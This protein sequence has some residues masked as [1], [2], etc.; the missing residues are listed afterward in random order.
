MNAALRS[1]KGALCA[2]GPRRIE[3]SS[4]NPPVIVFTDGACEPQGTSVGGILYVPGER[5]QAFGAMLSRKAVMCLASKEHQEQV[6]GQAEILPVLIAK[7][8]WGDK[9]RNRKVI[10]FIDNDSARLAL[11]KGYSPVLASLLLIMTSA[12]QDAELSSA[13]WYARVPTHSNPADEPSRMESTELRKK[14]ALLVEPRLK[15]F[16]DWFADILKMGAADPLPKKK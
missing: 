16:N 4:C 6:I 15:G 13:P 7:S 14:G 5:I 1:L 3:P 11:I 2:A 8:I 10:Y 9:L 12:Q